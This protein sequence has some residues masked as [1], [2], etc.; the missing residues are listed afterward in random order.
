MITTPDR[1][2]ILII[3]DQADNIR[4]LNEFLQDR[5]RIVFATDGERGLHLAL[6]QQ[7]DLIL[8]DVVM[9]EMDGHEVCRH[10]MSQQET[11]G[12]PVIF[13]T[14]LQF[15]EMET[16]GL[17]LGAVDYVTKPFKIEVVKQRIKNH[18][19][20]KQYRDR[21]E[22]TVAIQTAELRLA[23]ENAEAGDRAKRDL[24][25]LFSHELR[26]PLNSILGFLELLSLTELNKKQKE[27][28]AI[29]NESSQSLADML[30]GILDLVEMELGQIIP[31]NTPF[32]LAE[33]LQE[34]HTK[35][36][37]RAQKKGIDLQL[38]DDAAPFPLAIGS[39]KHLAKV[40]DH[41]LDNAIKF[42]SQGLIAFGVVR[43]TDRP[44]HGQFFVRDTG[45]GIEEGH[46]E[47]I[48]Q[49]FTQVE[50]VLNRQ[51]GG[52]GLGLV[53]C[54]KVLARF[55]EGRLW[56]ESTVGQGSTFFFE[57]KLWE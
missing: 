23:K 21:L 55:F 40:L 35:H 30:M 44:D 41:L 22:Q 45:V 38:Q 4:L 24:L 43:S 11:R 12:I 28:C 1:P 5:Y 50:A 3:D 20:L 54:N 47:F 17:S 9:P 2:T 39:R 6:E 32:D 34:A 25:G 10:L 37:L 7:P 19:E 26:T 33:V 57:A 53:W 31:D 52:L 51:H 18:L 13:C 14:S 56:V 36:W 15:E 48:M 42:T 46:R 16:I 49:P 27:Y 29:I 8:L